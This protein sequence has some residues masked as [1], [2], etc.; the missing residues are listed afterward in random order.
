MDSGSPNFQVGVGACQERGSEVTSVRHHVAPDE[1]FFNHLCVDV[2]AFTAC[3]FVQFKDTCDCRYA[4]FGNIENRVVIYLKD[5]VLSRYDLLVAEDFCV[6]GQ[7]PFEGQ[8][9][10][11]FRFTCECALKHKGVGNDKHCHP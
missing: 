10:F 6:V 3:L 8:N 11:H 2:A 4:P 5:D 7:H 1:V 9:A